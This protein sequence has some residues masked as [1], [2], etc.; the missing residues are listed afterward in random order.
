MT[1]IYSY[2]FKNKQEVIIAD[3]CPYDPRKA[4]IWSLGVAMFAIISYR[5]PFTRSDYKILYKQQLKRSWL[6]KRVYTCFS[7]D[8]FDLIK[9]MLEPMPKKR[10]TASQVIQHRWIKNYLNNNSGIEDLKSEASFSSNKLLTDLNKQIEKLDLNNANEINENSEDES[11]N[12]ESF[13]IISD[14]SDEICIS[15]SILSTRTGLDSQSC[16]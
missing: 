16:I 6:T 11:V 5:Y 15:Q 10:L 13:S 7:V 4:D 1:F 9:C 12:S 2:Y 8:A 3:R 14:E